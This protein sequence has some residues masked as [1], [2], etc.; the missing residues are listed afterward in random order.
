M[1]SQKIEMDII[2]K[3]TRL[4]R[5]FFP[6]LFMPVLLQLLLTLGLGTLTTFVDAHDFHAH[7]DSYGPIPSDHVAIIHRELGCGGGGNT[8]YRLWG[9]FDGIPMCAVTPVPNGFRIK[10]T[11]PAKTEKHSAGLIGYCDYSIGYVIELSPA[12]PISLSFTSPVSQVAEGTNATLNWSVTGGTSVTCTAS[13]DWSG[14]KQTQSPGSETVGPLTV[15]SSF[16]LSCS[17]PAVATVSKT[18]SIN[19]LPVG[20]LPNEQ[21]TYLHN[22]ALGSP[23]AA[24]N[25][26]GELLWKE[27]YHPYGDQIRKEDGGTHDNWF[28]GKP[29]DKDIGLSYFGARWYDPTIGRFMAMDPVGFKEGNVHSFNRY[30]YANGNPYKY[31]DPDGRLAL[32]T[33]EI[34]GIIVI[35]ALAYQALPQEAR[36][37]LG[38]SVLDGLNNLTGRGI[39]GIPLIPPVFNNEEANGDNSKHEGSTG[40]IKAPDV[41]PAFPDAIPV[42]PKT[43]VQGGGGKRKRWKNK[44]NIFEWDSQHGTVEVYGKSGKN[45]K[46]EF[47][48]NTGKRLKPPNEGRSVEK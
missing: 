25:S 20:T 28:T 30:A 1:S 45:H 47:D 18:V 21:V 6:K 24:T 16:V 8:Y 9:P 3:T 7:C 31:V 44:K 36:D 39:N 4:R 13:G 12:S 40:P 34:V 29:Y 11:F 41:L 10:S 26:Q 43:S 19:V 42:K 33:V 15:N 22:D 37:Q 27:A 5:L 35:G 17:D 23:A 14:Q 32:P 48:P 2:N 38:R 46:G